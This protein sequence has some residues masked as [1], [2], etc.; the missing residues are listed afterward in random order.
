MIYRDFQGEKLSGLGLGLMRLPTVGGD[1]SVIDEAAAAE[2]VDMAWRGGVNYFDTAWGYHG[3]RSEEFVGKC[4]SRYPRESYFLASKLPGYD[5]ANIPKAKEIFEEQLRRCRTG[6]FD[7]YLLHNVYEANIDAYLDPKNGALEY[8]LEQKKNGRIRHLG[9]STHGAP[10]NV[11]QFLDRCGEHMEFCQLQ[12]NYIDWHFQSA[13]E[14]V[15]MVT[16]AGLPVWI[17]EPLRGG[18]LAQAPADVAEGMRAMRP[19][20]TVPGWAVR[21]VQSVP[22]VG[23]VL[24]GISTKE[25]MEDSLRLWGTDEPLNREEF[26]R[27]V[28]LGDLE[29]GR[30]GV[31]CTGCRY[32]VSYCP[33]KLPIPKLLAFYNEHTFTGGGLRAPLG[34]GSMPQEQ[35]PAN[36]LACGSCEAVCPQQIKISKALHELSEMIGM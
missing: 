23:V 36:C 13:R 35:R 6:Y 21:F 1:D 18:K 7:F 22:H 9:F 28:E 14:K 3:G 25:Q 11:R 19:H 30:A 29:S 17:M 24:S 32:C 10:D 2:M 31:P 20:E 33:Q 16:G 15:E 34:V 8:L 5:V 26:D 27:L 12:V 4:L